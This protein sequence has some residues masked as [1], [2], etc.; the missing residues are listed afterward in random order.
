MVPAGIAS[1]GDGRRPGLFH[2]RRRQDQRGEQRCRGARPEPG[3]FCGDG[4]RPAR[5]ADSRHLAR[6]CSRRRPSR[7]SPRVPLLP[8]PTGIHASTT[9]PIAS[10]TAV[11]AVEPSGDRSRARCRRPQHPKPRPAIR[12]PPQR[13]RRSADALSCPPGGA[14]DSIQ[15]RPPAPPRTSRERAVAG[16][17]DTPARNGAAPLARAGRARSRRPTRSRPS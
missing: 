10:Q 14:P 11:D 17:P 8:R 12:A 16:Q 2:R 15:S 3:W 5:A 6:A 4:D 7:D 13:L 1:V 9:R